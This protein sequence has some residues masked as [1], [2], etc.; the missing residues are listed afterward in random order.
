MC[1]NRRLIQRAIAKVRVYPSSVIVGDSDRAPENVK[2][3]NQTHSSC[4]QL[5]P[6]P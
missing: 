1:A 4:R 6:D 3:K 5:Q 2:M